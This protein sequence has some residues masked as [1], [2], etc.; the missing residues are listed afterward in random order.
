MIHVIPVN[1]NL[2]EYGANFIFT[3]PSNVKKIK[4][5][6]AYLQDTALNYAQFVIDEVSHIGF[7]SII[8]NNESDFVIIDE[9][10]EIIGFKQ[11][12]FDFKTNDRFSYRNRIRYI[13]RDVNP[14]AYHKV[15][16]KAHEDYFKINGLLRDEGFSLSMNL[17]IDCDD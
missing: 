4:S 9:E 13:N 1:L 17:M 8:L 15:I 10:I 11:K 7:F 5:I 16:V 3:L 14:N 6:A 12:V 2:E